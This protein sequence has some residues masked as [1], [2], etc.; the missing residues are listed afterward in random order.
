MQA[1]ILCLEERDYI[2]G[3]SY[4]Y[5]ALDGFIN[6]NSDEDASRALKYLTLAK[7]MAGSPESVRQLVSS[8]NVLKYYSRDMQA[9]QAA[10]GAYKERNLQQFEQVLQEYSQELQDDAIVYRHLGSIRDSLLEQNL[11]RILEPYSRVEISYIA[12]CIQL[13]VDYVEAKLSKLI[14]DEHLHGML[15]QNV[16]VVIM[17]DP[18]HKD[19]NF[20]TAISIVKA[21]DGVVDKFNTKADTLSAM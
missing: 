15:D 14:L 18:V 3:Y 12:K 20:S 6:T 16:G 5:E 2:T 1:G 10:A 13:P 9:M 19:T 8:K 7:I 21:L 17:Y 4:F 11:L